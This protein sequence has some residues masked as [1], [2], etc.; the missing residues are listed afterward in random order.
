M[1]EQRPDLAGERAELEA[2][3]GSE[4][5]KRAPSLAQLLSYICE[6]H[7]TGEGSQIR[8]YNIAVAALGRPT[9]F[10]QKR[11]SIVRVEAHR[12]RKRLR[13]C[14]E[15]EG[16]GHKIRLELPLGGYTPFFRHMEP[17]EA[18][19]A[20]DQAAGISSG[21]AAEG[22]SQQAQRGLLPWIAA[23]AAVGLAVVAAVVAYLK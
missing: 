2:V 21:A 17:E 3:L 15:T 10:D 12:L 13:Q 20:A 16:A 23:A 7:F 22:S 18:L 5:F 9:D 4:I 14:Y 11:D 8:E 19:V 1:T 6:R